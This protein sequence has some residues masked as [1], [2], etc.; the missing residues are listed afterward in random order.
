M[1]AQEARRRQLE[2][3]RRAVYARQEERERVVA[4]VPV[5]GANSLPA[6]LQRAYEAVESQMS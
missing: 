1:S 3:R 6:E 2:A 4:T 5:A